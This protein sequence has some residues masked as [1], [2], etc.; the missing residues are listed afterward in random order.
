MQTTGYIKIRGTKFLVLIRH[1][2]YGRRLKLRK[3][4]KDGVFLK[5]ESIFLEENLHLIE[6]LEKGETIFV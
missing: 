4:G 6:K 3:S 5:D 1:C 2:R